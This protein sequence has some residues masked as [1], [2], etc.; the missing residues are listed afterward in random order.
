MHVL[1]LVM[2]SG[3]PIIR[4]S[5]DCNDIRNKPVEHL[6]RVHW[7]I[8]VFRALACIPDTGDGCT[9]CRDPADAVMAEEELPPPPP[10]SSRGGRLVVSCA[11][12]SCR[13]SNV[14][15]LPLPLL[16]PSATINWD[17]VSGV[18]WSSSTAE[19][20]LWWLLARLEEGAS[21]SLGS[22]WQR[23]P[24]FRFIQRAQGRSCATGDCQWQSFKHRR[25]KRL[26][27]RNWA[28]RTRSHVICCSRVD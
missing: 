19:L 1:K 3:S 8:L 7:L 2:W 6:L 23:W 26:A 15:P 20:L 11:C 27:C 28:G 22:S 25:G 10:L 18:L 17:V 4:V 12:W 14:L 9:S 13:W 5:D 24:M 21:G 16:M